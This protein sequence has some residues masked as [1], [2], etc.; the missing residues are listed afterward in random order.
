MKKIQYLHP[1]LYQHLPSEVPPY[2]KIHFVEGIALEYEKEKGHVNWCAFGADTN[3]RQI[4]R[5]ERDVQKL[6]AL[7]K[8][9]NT[10]KL[11][12]VHGREWHAIRVEP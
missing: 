9:I 2:V 7:W 11:L 6:M 12:K 8:T 10:K 1:I 3:K 4:N 5:Y